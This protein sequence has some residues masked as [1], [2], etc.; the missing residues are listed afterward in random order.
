MTRLIGI[1]GPMKT[2]K[3][4][5][6]ARLSQV[7]DLPVVSYAE[8]VRQEVSEPSSTSNERF[9]WDALESA[10]KSLRARFCKRGVR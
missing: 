9:L 2:G 6:A 3:S 10:D 4:T 1:A 5:L 8:A 7:F